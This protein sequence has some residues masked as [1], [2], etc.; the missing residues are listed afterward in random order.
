MAYNGKNREAGEK[1]G[2]QKVWDRETGEVPSSRSDKHGRH[3][4]EN[5]KF[6][7]HDIPRHGRERKRPHD[8]GRPILL[9]AA[10]NDSRSTS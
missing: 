2:L 4:Y 8:G 1:Y 9:F 3:E 5:K 10:A 7:D 6:L